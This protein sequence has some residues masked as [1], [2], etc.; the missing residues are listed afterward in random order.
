MIY[1]IRADNHHLTI[2]D[3]EQSA[4]DIAD[5]LYR[6]GAKNIEVWTAK[7]NYAEKGRPICEDDLKSC[8]WCN[9]KRIAPRLIADEITFSARISN[10]GNT[11]AIGISSEI[12]SEMCLD[13]GDMVQVTIKRI[14]RY[15]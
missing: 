15:D 13:T 4:I 5:G 1:A 9:G 8:I 14:S 2:F 3:T 6:N 11:K 10:K 7:D 12:L